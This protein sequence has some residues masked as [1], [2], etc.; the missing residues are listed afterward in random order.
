M[1]CTDSTALENH[2]YARNQNA[3]LRNPHEFPNQGNDYGS[4]TYS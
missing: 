3:F 1:G 2:M 4:K